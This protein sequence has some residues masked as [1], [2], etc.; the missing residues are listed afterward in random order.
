MGALGFLGIIIHDG[1]GTRFPPYSTDW[2][3]LGTSAANAVPIAGLLAAMPAGLYA[4][5]RGLLWALGVWSGSLMVRSFPS[6]GR[7]HYGPDTP[8]KRP[9]DCGGP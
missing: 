2:S 7:K 4:L 6:N 1:I 8:R 3:Q 9:H 5:G